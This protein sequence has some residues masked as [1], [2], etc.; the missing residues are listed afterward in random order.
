MQG[1]DA[2][3][4]FC[5]SKAFIN[6]LF[7]TGGLTGVWWVSPVL[8]KSSI[9]IYPRLLPC[10]HGDSRP[11]SQHQVRAPWGGW[12]ETFAKKHYSLQKCP[13]LTWSSFRNLQFSLTLTIFLFLF[14][15]FSVGSIHHYIQGQT[16]HTMT[17]P[18]SCEHSKFPRWPYS[19]VLT[20][21]LLVSVELST[22]AAS[23]TTWWR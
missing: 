16:M 19:S 2:V 5:T 4:S 10:C 3:I 7:P 21:V 18:H 22:S 11:E 14:F 6:L 20:F 15:F 12:I 23:H 8:G 13:F 17:F 9:A 1:L